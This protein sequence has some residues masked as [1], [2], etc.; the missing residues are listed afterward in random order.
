MKKDIDYLMGLS[1]NPL[2]LAERAIATPIGIAEQDAI[3]ITDA[4]T[5]G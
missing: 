3:C 5:N 2:I 1:Q 4:S